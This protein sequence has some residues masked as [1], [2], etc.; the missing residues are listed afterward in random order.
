MDL[1]GFRGS[2]RHRTGKAKISKLVESMA[3]T[4]TEGEQDG[5]D[6]DVED[7]NPADLEALGMADKLEQIFDLHTRQRM[8]PPKSRKGT[9]QYPASSGTSSPITT[10]DSNLR[11]SSPAT[12]VEKE[13]A[14]KENLGSAAKDLV[15][16]KRGVSIPSQRRFVRY[17]SRVLVKDDPR[18]LDLLAPPNASRIERVR[19]QVGI[20]EVRV[21]MPDKMPGFP[22]ILGKKRISVHLGRYRTSFVDDLERRELK[23]R[24][25]HRLEKK[26]QKAH[27]TGQTLQAEEELKLQELL[28]AWT[29]WKDDDWQDKH[30]LFEKEGSLVEADADANDT[31][32]EQ[33][34]RAEVSA[35][36]MIPSRVLPASHRRALASSTELSDD[37][38]GI[39][40]THE[41]LGPISI[42]PPEGHAL[43]HPPTFQ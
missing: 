26:R 7:G 21:Y 39:L 32:E 24:V 41:F 2:D 13:G 17:W 1:A 33:D 38:S 20:T 27:K 23:L 31:D 42:D 12:P 25:L 28:E 22:A 36:R 30:D 16:P 29:S 4:D 11:T 3:T 14:T 15:K 8:K 35:R 9:G 5:E 10:S 40:H 18:P 34:T 37:G 6:G 19:R 43:S